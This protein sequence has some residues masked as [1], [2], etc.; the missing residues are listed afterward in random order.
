VKADARLLTDHLVITV[1][2]PSA[3]ADGNEP[4][5]PGRGLS[6]LPRASII[7]SSSHGRIPALAELAGVSSPELPQAIAA[8]LGDFDLSGIRVLDLVGPVAL[9]RTREL[10]QKTNLVAMFA[11]ILPDSEQVDAL[12]TRDRAIGVAKLNLKFRIPL[13]PNGMLIRRSRL[14][15][16]TSTTGTGS[17]GR[18][19]PPFPVYVDRAIWCV[20]LHPEDVAIR[21]R[22]A[23]MVILPCYTVQAEER[24][25][26]VLRRAA[27]PMHHTTK[28]NR[29]TEEEA[30][31]VEESGRHSRTINTCADML[32]LLF[33]SVLPDVGSTIVGAESLI[34]CGWL[35]EAGDMPG[36]I[37]ERF[38]RRCLEWAPDLDQERYLRKTFVTWDEY[39]ES[40]D[41]ELVRLLEETV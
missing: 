11:R 27:K 41:P 40:L 2:Y 36:D 18:R 20:D 6:T 26:L 29:A 30:A 1:T 34:G 3:P 33:P 39:R 8:Q 13:L 38:R 35:E 24:P 19:H 7:V 25:V 10:L 17:L 28:F 22:G 9:E 32:R 15:A 4:S 37:G 23:Q 21:G 12:R 16:L 5:A 14:P 31:L